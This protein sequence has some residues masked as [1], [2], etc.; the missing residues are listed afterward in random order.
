MTKERNSSFE[1]LRIFAMLLIIGHHFVWYSGIL[2]TDFNVC[3]NRIPAQVLYIG[4]PLGVNIFFMLSG[5]FY[6]NKYKTSKLARIDF[7]MIFYSVAALLIS[8]LLLKS[9]YN[10]K[11]IIKTIMPLSTTVYWFLTVYAIVYITS[12]ILNLIVDKLSKKAFIVIGL[13]V[14]F[15]V[16]VFPSIAFNMS[17]IHFNTMIIRG[18]IGYFIGAYMKKYSVKFLDSIPKALICFILSYALLAVVSVY[19]NI[20]SAKELWNNAQT[21]LLSHTS[22][23]LLFCAASLIMLAKNI[24]IGSI[25]VINF[26]SSAVLGVYI[27]HDQPYIRSYIW[28]NILK[29]NTSLYSENYIF[30]AFRS[31]F[32]VFLCC[33]A[34][35]IIRKLLT[36]PLLDKLFGK[37][38]FFSK[39]D[40]II[41]LK[42]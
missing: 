37:I 17:L 21:V 25:K 39:L 20:Y 40:N 10:S 35:E 4:G 31:I 13:M 41:N 24:N 32:I 19:G 9:T 1:L 22:L 8:V 34:I 5:Y 2:S 29:T 3:P 28:T 7:S 16:S 12:P 26:I 38:K 27:I 36:E 18:F 33:A 15:P 23:P 11:D 42:D 6:G 14:L 30:S